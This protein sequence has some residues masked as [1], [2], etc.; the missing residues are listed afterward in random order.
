[1]MTLHSASRQSGVALLAALVLVMTVVLIMGNIFYRHQINVAQTALSLHQDQ[2]NLLALSGES[3]A[4]QLLEDDSI[5]EDHFEE[6]WAQ[7]IPAM[8]VDGGLLNGCIS[9]LQGLFNL[10]NFASINTTKLKTAFSS[11][12]ASFPTIW[13]YLLNLQDIPVFPERVATIIDWV[14]KHSALVNSYGAEQDEYASLMPPRMAGDEL[15]AEPSELAAVIGYEIF[16][17]QKLM[18][19]ITALPIPSG[20]TTTPININTASDELLLALGGTT[21]DLQFRDFVVANR[22]FNDINRFYSDL[23][24]ELG[25]ALSPG[26]TKAKDRWP[27]TLVNVK[28]EY[29]Q[30]YIEVILGEARIEVKSIIHRPSRGNSAIISRELTTVPASLAKDS[31]SAL[32]EKLA[33]SVGLGSDDDLEEMVEDQQVQ[34]ACLM[35]GA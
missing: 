15:M 19:W 6:T 2:A 21:Y 23:D 24:I 14:D 25:F 35:I 1:M 31:D 18:P 16:E 29:F 26:G 11:N 4:R 34:P 8:P 32:F 13:N 33:A 7:A 5:S 12:K 28:S 10:N 30:L 17:V 22:P 3:W 27:D 20:S 9:D